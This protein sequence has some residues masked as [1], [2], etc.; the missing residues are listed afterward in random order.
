MSNDRVSLYR[1][2]EKTMVCVRLSRY[3]DW[4]VSASYARALANDLL[5]AAAQ[6]D[7]ENAEKT[8]AKQSE[9]PSAATDEP[10]GRSA[11]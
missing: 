4:T 2:G 8:E 3:E 7:G 9:G 6:A 5:R 10:S 1:A 11:R